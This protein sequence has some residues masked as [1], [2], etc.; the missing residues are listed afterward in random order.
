[1]PMFFRVQWIQQLRSISKPDE[2]AGSDPPVWVP[3]DLIS[4]EMHVLESQVRDLPVDHSEP[5]T[6]A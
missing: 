6:P 2:G 5:K 4:G 1:M 3:D